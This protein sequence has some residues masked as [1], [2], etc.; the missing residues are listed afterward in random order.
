MTDT[1]PRPA[2]SPVLIGVDGRSG[3]GKSTFADALAAR[4]APHARVGVL[5]IESMY[6]DW[7]G[8]AAVLTPD[9]PYARALRDLRAGRPA[10]WRAWDWHRAAP[11][12]ETVLTLGDVV[13][14]EGV[15]A[16][17]AAARDLL[18]LRVWLEL[19]EPSR[20]T[21]ALARDGETYA[22][23]WSRWATQEERYLDA[24]RPAAAADVTTSLAGPC[25]TSPS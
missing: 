17:C 24:D 25:P 11:G 6:T 8:L 19:D 20:R 3:A 12:E 9:S 23:H 14:C 2:T 22:P 15:G 21:R 16:L 1:T 5:R 18:D 4:L 13:V 10:R 7:D